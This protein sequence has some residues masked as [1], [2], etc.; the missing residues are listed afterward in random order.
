MLQCCWFFIQGKHGILDDMQHRHLFQCNNNDLLL[1]YHKAQFKLSSPFPKIQGHIYMPCS[2]IDCFVPDFL[3]K[4]S[5]RK[6][7][8]YFCSLFH[9]SSLSSAKNS[10]CSTARSVPIL[11]LY[12]G[13]IQK[14][15]Y[16]PK[17]LEFSANWFQKFQ[18]NFDR[19]D[20]F[21]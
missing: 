18:V 17:L 8:E 20:L 3:C 1:C 11:P 16:L 6:I 4:L 9:S 14:G 12:V 19:P 13:K 7:H 15:L 5:R 2:N 10:L 21:Q